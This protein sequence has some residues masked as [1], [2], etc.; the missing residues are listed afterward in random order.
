[1]PELRQ[2]MVTDE[3]VIIATER[4]KRPDD[5]IHPSSHETIELEPPLDQSCPFCPGNEELDLEVERMPE[6]KRWQTRVVQNKFPAL[7]RVGEIKHSYNGGNRSITGIGHHE[8]IVDHPRHNTTW[9]LMTAEEIKA[10]LET[11]F[12]CGWRIREDPRIK[13]I[14]YFKNHGEQAGASL[15]H[16]HSQIMA[17]PIIP[18]HIWQRI[19]R[20]RRYYEDTG[21][22]VMHAMMRNELRNGQRIV[23]LGDHFVAF[24]LYAAANPFHIWIIPHQ[25]CISFLDSKPAQIDELAQV[26]R[27]VLRRLYIGL[28]DPG[29]N[30]IIRSAPEENFGEKYLQWYITIVPRLS[31]AAGFE[32]GS[33]MFINPALP[34]ES[35]EFLRNIKI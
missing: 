12:R 23:T 24:V 15:K 21:E 19:E 29:Y 16:P 18:S 1:M 20:A 32:L 10:V 22:A 27:D 5:F 30:L 3:W 7:S 35:A 13:Q 25:R 8:I 26:L 28:R 11:F 17:L 34:E 4:A 6:T 9:G 2:N 14:I 31:Q 33:G